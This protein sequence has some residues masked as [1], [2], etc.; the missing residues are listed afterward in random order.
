MKPEMPSEHVDLYRLDWQNLRRVHIKRLPVDDPLLV[1]PD[2]TPTQIAIGWATYY[3][4]SEPHTL[5]D[6]P[7]RPD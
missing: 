7:H 1:K 6:C 3:E 5:A 2:G 4:V